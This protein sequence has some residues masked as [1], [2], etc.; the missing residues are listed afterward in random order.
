MKRHHS[1]YSQIYDLD[2]LEAAWRKTRLGKRYDN[3][4]LTFGYDPLGNLIELH[5][6]L[7]WKTYRI[8]RYREFIV[9]EPKERL[10]QSLP[11]RDR[12]VQQALHQVIE[13]IFDTG[14]IYD[15]YA[16]RKGKGTHKAMKRLKYFLCAARRKWGSDTPIH[17]LHCDIRKYFP[18]IDHDILYELVCRK[19]KD[20]D[21]LRLIRAIIDSSTCNPG[22]PI[23]SLFSQL[24]ANIYMNVVDQFVKHDLRERFYLRYMDNFI[25][26]HLDKKHLQDVKR[27]IEGVLNNRL[28]LELNP[29]VT[30]IGRAGQ[31]IDFV[32]YRVYADRVKVRRDGIKRMKRRLKSMQAMYRKGIMTLPDITKRIHSWLGH[33]SHADASGMVSSVLKR[34]VFVKG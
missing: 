29:K 27:E 34:A 31:G 32:G 6:E 22:L 14:F 16:C 17:Y 18:H 11:L 2:N 21:T 13:P 10:I 7:V 33:C 4:V 5:N 3:E 1:L 9:R 23:G 24:S 20:K 12:I 8:G 15:S 19:I 30:I 25:V 26:I 28:R